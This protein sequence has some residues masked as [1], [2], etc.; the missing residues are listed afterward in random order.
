MLSDN[1]P[2]DNLIVVPRDRFRSD[3]PPYN[4]LPSQPTPL[5][6]REREVTLG[7][8]FLRGRHVRLLTLVGPGGV[9]K[10]R[11]GIEIAVQALPDFADG[12]CYVELTPVT[13]PALVVPTIA[14]TLGLGEDPEHTLQAA[15]ID[16]LRDRSVLLVLDNFEQVLPAGKEIASLLAACPRIK[17]L[18]TSREPL[19]L[20]GEQE[21][22]VQPLDLPQ[23]SKTSSPDLASLAANPAVALFLQRTIA[24]RPDFALTDANASAIAQVCVRLDGLP[25]AIELATARMKVLTPQALFARLQSSLHILTGGPADLPSRQQTLRDTI[26]WSYNLLDEKEQLAFRCLAVLVGGSTIEAAEALCNGPLDTLMSLVDK[27]LLRRVD[28]PNIEPRLAM[29]E[30]IRQYA[31]ERLEESGVAE[32]VRRRH[33]EYFLAL[34]EEAEPLLKGPDQI[35]WLNRLDH[36]RDN[37]RAVLAWATMESPPDDRRPTTARSLEKSTIGLKVAGCLL[38]FWQ[39]RGPLSEGHEWLA[40]LLALDDLSGPAATSGDIERMK[41]RARALA[42][43]GRIAYLMSYPT[44]RAYYAEYR[45]LCRTLGDR[46]GMAAA[47]MGMANLSLEKGD[48]D[49]AFSIY[50]EC[51][52]IS[53]EIGS[54]PG[55]AGALNNI[56]M[57]EIVRG[58]YDHA[59]QLMSEGLEIIRQVGDKERIA[60]MTDGLGRILLRKGELERAASTIN[61][62]LMMVTEM[63]DSWATAY[64]LEGLAEVACAQGK[65]NRVAQLLGAAEAYYKNMRGRLD[66][67]DI[68]T[69]DRSVAAAR[70]LL[71]DQA[72]DVAFADGYGKTAGQAAAFEEPTAGRKA[73][74]SR[75]KAAVDSG[76]TSN[77]GYPQGAAIRNW[78]SVLSARELEVLR[79]VAQGL[80]DADIAAQLFLSR[81]TVNAHLRNIYSK[82]GVT[83]RSA[84]TRYAIDHGY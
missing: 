26:E 56:S 11:L 51:L 39:V 76:V 74:S 71:G 67:L 38:R 3:E 62:S 14:Q 19:R 7:W 65:P 21:I 41:A 9:G 15:L 36:D 78:E 43:A 60:T 58:N 27:S 1:K 81:H 28:H 63:Q 34:A 64:S 23:L 46:A 16:Y 83:S 53:R 70:A 82:L 72:Y 84:A 17:V 2:Q 59:E 45:D 57:V 4:N 12:V 52:A 40:R 33:A 73:E 54:K 55:V 25:L 69:Y 6:G 48:T 44:C 35:E 80:S 42:T 8:S 32:E 13:D 24:V 68:E 5:V 22:Q 29:L 31:L 77:P 66:Y 30:T 10:T 49:E 18:V 50:E 37:L 75:Q 79:L 61:S 47:L 20:R